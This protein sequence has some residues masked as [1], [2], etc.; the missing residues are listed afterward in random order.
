LMITTSLL[1][2]TT[3]SISAIYSANTITRVANKFRN[4]N[5]VTS[6]TK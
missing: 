2:L 5:S 4:R 6:I 3:L 1:V